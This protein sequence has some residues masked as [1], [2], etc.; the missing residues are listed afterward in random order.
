MDLGLVVG[1]SL[2]ICAVSF[3]I[4][5]LAAAGM[6]RAAGYFYVAV[7]PPSLMRL[8]TILAQ[9]LEEWQTA[10]AAKRGYELPPP[11]EIVLAL[12]AFAH[13]ERPHV[14]RSLSQ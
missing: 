10:E 13:R 14:A 4:T 5:R 7:R 12:R 3:V 9:R 2:A 11:P 8:T 1:V 6:R